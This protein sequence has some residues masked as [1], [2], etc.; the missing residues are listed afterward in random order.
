MSCAKTR[1]VP[2][3]SS[4][5]AQ[6]RR[7]ER[8]RWGVGARVVL[9]SCQDVS[10]RQA[11]HEACTCMRTW[12]RPFTLSSCSITPPTHLKTSSSTVARQTT[13][14]RTAVPCSIGAT[15][16]NRERRGGLGD[17]KHS[18]LIFGSTPLLVW[19][20]VTCVCEAVPVCHLQQRR[21]VELQLSR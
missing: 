20:K 11:P 1:D 13:H 18:I 9:K 15:T 4:I 19:C 7:K 6:I 17:N 2:A 10:C 5:T 21:S 12:S 3:A 14:P 8:N 16:K